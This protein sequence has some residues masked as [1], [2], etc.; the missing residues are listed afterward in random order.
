MNGGMLKHLDMM[1]EL[2][3]EEDSIENWQLILEQSEEFFK[4]SQ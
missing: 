4:L 2:R 3:D 1:L